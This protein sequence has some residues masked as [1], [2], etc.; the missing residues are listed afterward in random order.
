MI[1][2]QSS[3]SGGTGNPPVAAGNLPAAVVPQGRLNPPKIKPKSN[4]CRVAPGPMALP[5]QAGGRPQDPK[6]KV[7]KTKK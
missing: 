7:N 3:V 2:A 1:A 4:Q 6:I 5:S